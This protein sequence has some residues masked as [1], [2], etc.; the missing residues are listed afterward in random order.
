MNPHQVA[1]A[2]CA[3]LESRLRYAEGERD[4]VLM[5]HTVGVRYA[6][7][8]PEQASAR[9]I[10]ASTCAHMYINTFKLRARPMISCDVVLR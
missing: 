1:E 4:A 2:F 6:D 8:R 3:L 10:H 9:P 7:G 5:E